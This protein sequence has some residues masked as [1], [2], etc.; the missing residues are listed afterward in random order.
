M[1]GHFT[2]K[3]PAQFLLSAQAGAAIQS[4]RSSNIT[5]EE[6]DANYAL[7][8]GVLSF[9]LPGFLRQ[10]LVWLAQRKP[11]RART[12]DRRLRLNPALNSTA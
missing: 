3:G 11:Q 12:Q 1:A 10:A 4:S 7:A 2:R 6:C 8:D 9:C 5:R